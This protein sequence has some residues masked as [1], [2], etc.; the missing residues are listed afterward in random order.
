[1][2]KCLKCKQEKNV[3]EFAKKSERRDGLQ[4]WCRDCKNAYSRNYYKT[5]DLKDRLKDKN[6]ARRIRLRDEIREYKASKGCKFCPE[7]EPC[8]LQF[9]HM[10]DDKID[11]VANLLDR[12]YERLWNEISKCD[13]VC[14]NCHFKL[15][16][17]IMGC[18]RD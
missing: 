13:V 15:H 2:K 14:A 1:M 11:N 9:H 6:T 8:C 17:G 18:L 5:T 16:A 10:N 12:S 4:T 3:S 7:R